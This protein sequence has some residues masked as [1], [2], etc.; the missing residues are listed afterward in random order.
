VP[1]SEYAAH[2]GVA[3]IMCEQRELVGFALPIGSHRQA[4][5]FMEWFG[6]RFYNTSLPSEW[7]DI[8]YADLEALLHGVDSWPYETAENPSDLVSPTLD[9]ARLAEVT[10]G[11]IPV[12]SALGPAVLVFEN[13]D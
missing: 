3:A 5:V 6:E 2:A 8:D 1:P 7:T 4:L 9:R 12:M 11:W 10:E 13:S